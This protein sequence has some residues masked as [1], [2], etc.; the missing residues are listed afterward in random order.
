MLAAGLGLVELNKDFL[1][2]WNANS[3]NI[4]TEAPLEANKV[5]IEFGISVNTINRVTD[6]D[7]FKN[8]GKYIVLFDGGPKEEMI[9]DYGENDFLITYD[10]KYYFSFRQFKFNRR[11]Q[12]DYNFYFRK[13]DNRVFVNVDIN[14]EDDMK[15]E[16]AMLLVSLADEYRCNVPVDSAVEVYNMIELV[17]PDK[18]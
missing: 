18:K 9:N 4:T 2:F 13:M 3:I 12:H 1:L 16:R 11:H 5:K 14:G 6:S 15:F 7:L 8:R 17:K 10:N